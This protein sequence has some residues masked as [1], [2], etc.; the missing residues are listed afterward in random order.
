MQ[1]A[2]IARLMIQEKIIAAHNAH[3]E[4]APEGWS[5]LIDYRNSPETAPNENI[6]YHLYSTGEVTSQKGAWAYLDRSEFTMLPEIQPRPKFPYKFPKKVYNN[7]Q[8]TYA[9]LTYEEAKM[10][11]QEMVDCNK[12]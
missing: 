12:I 8:L 4:N 9:I 10:F 1:E 2:E 5:G 6:I 7:D 11:R 3:Y